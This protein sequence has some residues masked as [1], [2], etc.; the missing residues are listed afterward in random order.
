MTRK[1][2]SGEEITVGNTT[3]KLYS[4]QRGER[5]IYS[6]NNYLEGK[7]QV[8]Q[9]SD[10]G[11]AKREANSIA[12]RLEAGQRKVLNLTDNDA[13]TYTRAV[14]YL[15]ATGQALDFAAKEYADAFT[16]LDGL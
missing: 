5:T 12:R 11:E 1:K 7:R 6:L 16:T 2:G 9:F 4:F 13:A 3:V 14:D 10:Y 15:K 8:R